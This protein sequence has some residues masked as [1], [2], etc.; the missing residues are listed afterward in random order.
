MSQ[1][2]T[3]LKNKNSSK[4]IIPVI[5]CGGSGTR[6][7]PLSRPEHPKQFLKLFS[8]FSLVQETVLRAQKA[9]GASN[10][11]IVCVTMQTSKDMLKNQMDALG[12]GYSDH[13]LPEP[14][15]KNTAAAV[16]YAACY[17]EKTFGKDAIMWV[18]PSDH[19]IADEAALSASLNCAAHAAK[20][21]AL[22]T[23]GIT[24]TRPE[25]GYGYIRYQKEVICEGA[26]QSAGFVEKP[27]IETAQKYLQSGDYLWNSGM[28]VMDTKTV[29]DHYQAHANELLS[30]VQTAMD[31]NPKSPD[32]HIYQDIEKTPF[33]KAIMEKSKNV[34][35]VPCDMG[36]SDIGSWARLWD[37][38][39]KYGDGDALINRPN[40]L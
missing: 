34:A 2:V 31:K 24:P 11:N 18:L 28:F 6:L 30:C 36:W 23:F 35:V 29:I 32:A 20:Q 16:A 9:S 10:E 5:L 14:Y 12:K 3:N 17:V 4:R 39:E 38:F 8:E 21:G 26:F 15:A 27:D 1:T 25:T 40:A 37:V 13:I 33:D 7:W 22:T 19:F